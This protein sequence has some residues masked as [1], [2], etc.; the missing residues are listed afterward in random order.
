MQHERERTADEPVAF[1]ALLRAARF[2]YGHAIREA[3]NEAGLDDIPKNGIFVIGAIS[4]T[5]APLAQII[6]SLGALQTIGGTT[7]RYA[8]AARLYRA[9]SRS[10]RPAQADRRPHRARTRGCRRRARCG[11]SAWTRR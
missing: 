9:R 4:R 6:D 3:L 1:A 5:G 10:R 11:R 2:A 7:R 8:R